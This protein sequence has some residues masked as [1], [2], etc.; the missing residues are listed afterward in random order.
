[1]Q[2]FV[3]VVK[4]LFGVFFYGEIKGYVNSHKLS[5]VFKIEIIHDRS[6]FKIVFCTT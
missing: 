3:F 5:V 4:C 1:M 6:I 2:L